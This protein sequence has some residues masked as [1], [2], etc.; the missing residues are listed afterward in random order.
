MF[1]SDYQV[2]LKYGARQLG[3]RGNMCAEEREQCDYMA[4]AA[5]TGGPFGAIPAMPGHSGGATP[6]LLL[7]AAA[8]LEAVPW[9]AGAHNRYTI[10]ASGLQRYAGERYESKF[11]PTSFASPVEFRSPNRRKCERIKE[12]GKRERRKKN[13]RPVLTSDRRRDK[14]KQ[15]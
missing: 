5:A 7:R 8:T 4:D 9:R 14:K 6:P 10:R 2:S 15:E 1:A 3:C 12:T 13:A 11:I